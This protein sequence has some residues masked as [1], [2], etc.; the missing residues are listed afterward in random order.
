MLEKSELFIYFLL[1]NSRQKFHPRQLWKKRISGLLHLR[2]QILQKLRPFFHR[3]QRHF[4]KELEIGNWFVLKAIQIVL[5]LEVLL[6]Q[7]LQNLGP[8]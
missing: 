1:S 4:L 5:K 2:P 3:Q 7:K 8:H 6:V